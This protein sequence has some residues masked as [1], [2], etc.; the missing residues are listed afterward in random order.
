MNNYFSLPE[1]TD[2]KDKKINFIYYTEEESE[3]R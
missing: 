2:Y 3:K 1:I